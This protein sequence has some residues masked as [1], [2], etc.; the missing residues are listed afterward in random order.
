LQDKEDFIMSNF[1]LRVFCCVAKNLSYTKAALELNITQPAITK[2]IHELEM[3]YKVRLFERMGNKI[4]LT[5]AGK[6]F[7]NHS[8]DILHEY[9]RLDFDMNILH[10]DY[11]G[12]LRIGASTTIAQ[13]VLPTILAKFTSKF[14]EIKIS[15]A[16]GNSD[17][18]E[19]ELLNHNIDL[20]LIEG[21]KRLPNLK[22]THFMDDELVAITSTKSRYAHLDE[23]S[24]EEFNTVPFVLR[25]NGSG[26]LSVLNTALEK[27][28]IKTSSL[29]VL[30]QL[31][32][33][34]SIKLFL[35]NAD[36]ISVISFRCVTREL[37]NEILKIIELPELEMKREF[38][39]MQLQ[40]EAE[41]LPSLFM[42]FAMHETNI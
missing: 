29:N 26:T 33:S 4:T 24:K 25:E 7:L 5:R 30:M 42:K 2:H 3:Q 8:I 22:Y 37:V 23:L 21:N 35:E 31:G 27:I 13:Y 39:F 28:G 15:L 10:G 38:C 17:D 1:R 18:I 6:V 19:K 14:P 34:E 16:S 41:G 12:T 32:S 40:G 36:A 11:N 9:S 20:G